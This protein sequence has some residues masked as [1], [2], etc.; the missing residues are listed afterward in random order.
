MKIV[1]DLWIFFILMDTS[2]R[3]FEEL[4]KLEEFRPI[5]LFVFI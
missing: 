5:F 4:S 3:S 2:T 1:E